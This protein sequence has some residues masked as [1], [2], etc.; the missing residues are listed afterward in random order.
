ML[1]LSLSESAR[2]WLEELRQADPTLSRAV[3]TW[4]RDVLCDPNADV[5]SVP[6]ENGSYVESVVDDA[7]VVVAWTLW[8]NGTI[9]VAYFD[10][11]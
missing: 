4:V 9:R 8:S 11:L 3:A 1:R 5:D 10:W 7:N 6:V 2:R